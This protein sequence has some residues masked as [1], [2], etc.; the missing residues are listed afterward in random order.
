[1]EPYGHGICEWRLGSDAA[2][3][4]GGGGEGRRGVAYQADAAVSSPF[5]S[6][7]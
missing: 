7:N 1:M 5:D 4:E 3:M 2:H 6:N